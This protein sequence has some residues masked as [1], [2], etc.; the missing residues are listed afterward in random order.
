MEALIKARCFIRFVTSLKENTFIFICF[1]LY[2]LNPIWVWLYCV[3]KTVKTMKIVMNVQ[4]KNWY[5]NGAG[6]CSNKSLNI[7]LFFSKHWSFVNWE[8]K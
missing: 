1:A 2:S 6:Y 7:L 8:N 5:E 4:I 3:M